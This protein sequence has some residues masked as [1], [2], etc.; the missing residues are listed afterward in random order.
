MQHLSSRTLKPSHMQSFVDAWT[1]S[2]AGS[3]ANP[4]AMLESVKQ[5]KILDT[6]FLIS[7]TESETAN[8]ELFSWKMLRESSPPRPV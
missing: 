2:L 1:S 3:R 8:L 7:E 6:S 5:L 4:S